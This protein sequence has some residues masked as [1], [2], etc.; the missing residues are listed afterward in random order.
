MKK[1]A[2]F[3]IALAFL[4]PTVLKAQQKTT[5]SSEQVI[6]DIREVK[7]PPIL[8]VTNLDFTD[9]DGNNCID[10]RENCQIS[11]TLQNSGKGSANLKMNVK[12]NAGLQGL[13]FTS[14]RDLELIPPGKSLDIEIPI[15][16][17]SQL[18]NGLAQFVIS[19][20]EAIGF[21]P[22]PIET[23][24]TTS[25]F[26]APNVKVVDSQFLSDNG[27]IGLGLPIQLKVLVQNIGQGIANDVAVAFSYPSKVYPNDKTRFAIGEL[28][29]GESREL[30]FE[31]AANRQ[32]TES[33]IPIGVKIS[34]S[35]GQY[36]ENEELTATVDAIANRPGPFVP[37][38][39][40]D[41]KNIKI[42]TASLTA[43]VDKNIPVN[44][45]K[46]KHRYAVIIGNE[47]YQKYQ[48]GLSSEAN[49]PYATS[50]A[51]V[52]KEYAEQTLGIPSENIYFQSNAIS[53]AMSRQIEQIKGIIRYER[54]NAEVFVYYSGHGFPDETTKMAYLMPV[55]ISGADVQR[56]ISLKSLYAS[57]TQYPSKRVTVFLDACFSGG[58]RN[59]GLLAANG[60]RTAGIVPD[61]EQFSG[62]LVVFSASSEAQ[63]ALPYKEMEHGM[64]TYFLLKYIQQSKGDITYHDL[65]EEVKSQVELK[66]M[67]IYKKN[68]NPNLIFSPDVEETWK[69]WHLLE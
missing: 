6:I 18:T 46:N 13:S 44:T 31:F 24:I 5:I 19:F 35:Y 20:T 29:P 7:L 15:N 41:D 16:A 38:P 48:P 54:G 33:G 68:Q 1:S 69:N 51:R 63:T 67:K 43:D 37:K 17:S 2:I 8:T 53:S 25:A 3:T 22:S 9:T 11:F 23:K 30:T 12:E 49:V 34:E 39:I 50:D 28:S 57:L 62:N 14:N 40:N 32:Y 52:F 61:E 4:L 42:E 58:G 21:P 55:D 59:L 26:K 47:D 10:G 60:E 36:S 27:V 66:I 45:T 64:F 65:Y 56:A